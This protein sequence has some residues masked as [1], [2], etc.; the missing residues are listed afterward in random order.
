MIWVEIYK[1][2][3]VYNIFLMFLYPTVH[4]ATYFLLLYTFLFLSVLLRNY[5]LGCF[6]NQRIIFSWIFAQFFYFLYNFLSFV[7]F[8]YDLHVYMCVCVYTHIIISLLY[9]TLNSS[10]IYLSRKALTVL[11]L[12]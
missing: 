2:T 10:F 8:S 4:I 1:P 7:S 3:H 11:S 12:I 6:F 5:L 9:Q